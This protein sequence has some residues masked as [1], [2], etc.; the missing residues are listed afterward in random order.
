MLHCV[1]THICVLKKKSSCR[2]VGR[3]SHVVQSHSLGGG[4]GG[5]RLPPRLGTSNNSVWLIITIVMSID[6]PSIYHFRV[7]LVLFIFYKIIF[8]VGREQAL[9]RHQTTREQ[10]PSRPLA[11]TKPPR[12]LILSKVIC[13][14][15]N[16]TLRSEHIRCLSRPCL[17]HSVAHNVQQ[18][19][20][21]SLQPHQ[22]LPPSP[23]SRR[24][25]ICAAAP[26]SEASRVVGAQAH[27]SEAQG[28]S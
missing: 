18:R 1:T 22:R 8:W 9:S 26:F 13:Y 2:P 14:L 19:G 23:T 17:P 15:V 3:T 25:G 16:S 7:V 21:V 10:A 27:S 20:V 5:A 24:R 4:D 12:N 11:D 6:E 28:S